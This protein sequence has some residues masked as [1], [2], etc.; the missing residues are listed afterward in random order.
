[1]ALAF[2]GTGDGRGQALGYCV[3]MATGNDGSRRWHSALVAQTTGTE[4]GGE[5]WWSSRQLEPKYGEER[6]GTEGPARHAAERDGGLV[7]RCRGTS[8]AGRDA[9]AARCCAYVG[10]GPASGP[11]SLGPARLN[12]TGS[13]LNQIFKLP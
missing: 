6:E 9:C 1:V 13:L 3:G 2:S 11:A 8:G 12:S 10:V 7:G 5:R 4:K